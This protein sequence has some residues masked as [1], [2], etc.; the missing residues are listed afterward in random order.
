MDDLRS[1]GAVK[2]ARGIY[3][4]RDA[5][6]EPLWEEGEL[7]D[8]IPALSDLGPPPGYPQRRAAKKRRKVS[9]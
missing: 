9:R 4:H 8:E 6:F 3:V 1:L 2:D 5:L 7:P